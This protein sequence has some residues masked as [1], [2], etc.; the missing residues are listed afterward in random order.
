MIE[1]MSKSTA[2]TT[3]T[4]RINIIKIE[5]PILSIDLM[6][7]NAIIPPTAISTSLVMITEHTYTTVDNISV[8]I[9]VCINLAFMSY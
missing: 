4:S 3:T 1:K 9:A 2:P 5:I 6:I 7:T 8:L